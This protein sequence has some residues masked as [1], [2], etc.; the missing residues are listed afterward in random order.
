MPGPDAI[1]TQLDIFLANHAA[2]DIAGLLGAVARAA[3]PVA[4]LIRRGALAGNL[5][6]ATGDANNDGDAQ[7][8]LDVAADRES[9][10]RGHLHSLLR[11]RGAVTTTPRNGEGRL[12]GRP[13]RSDGFVV[14]A[15]RR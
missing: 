8:F 5:A 4:A 7:K 10:R 3:T 9:T 12:E 6:A 15:S 11:G 2:P 14:R 1:G 13:S